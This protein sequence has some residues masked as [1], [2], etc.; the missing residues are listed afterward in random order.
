MQKKSSL[1]YISLFSSAG[2]GC[3][4][5]K[6]AQFSCLAT[7]E[8]LQKRIKFQKFNA[9]CESEDGY[10]SDDISKQETKN[11][12]IEI[13][14]KGLKKL[15]QST[16]DVLI[17]T[18]P[19]Q[20]M[21][22]A[23]HKKGDELPRNSLVIDSISLIK[24]L[25]PKIFVFE[26]V[27]S[28]LKTSCLDVDGKNK[29]IGDAIH[30]NLYDQYKYEFRKINFCEYGSNSSRTRCLVIGVR[31][32]CVNISPSNLF[33]SKV[34]P[35]K[36]REV[37][38]NLPTLN[39]GEIDEND[40][41]H[42]FRTY[43]KEM[44]EWI[45]TIRE[46]QSAF[47]NTEPHKRPHAIKDGKLLEHKR[48]NGDKYRRQILDKV[49]PCVHTRNDIL[50]SQNTVHPTEDRVF[51]IRELMRMMTIP[52]S[53][54]FSELSFKTL[55]NLSL[56]EKNKFL[57]NEELNIRHCIG[58]AVPTNIFF[59]I[60]E[61]IK[62]QFNNITETPRLKFAHFQTKYKVND[63]AQLAKFI[64][65]HGLGD[66][67]ISDFQSFSELL[68][69]SKEEHAAYYTNPDLVEEIVEN[70]PA[71]NE[72]RSIRILEPSVGSGAFITEIIKKYRDKNIT[73]DV[74]DI[75]EDA[76]TVLKSLINELHLKKT[77]KINYLIGD[78]LLHKFKK[79]YD[80]VIGNPPFLKINK[81]HTNHDFYKANARNSKSSNLFV[82]F[83]E[84]AIDISDYVCLIIPKSITGSPEFNETRKELASMNFYQIHDF[85]EHG[86]KGVLI[87]TVALGFYT[88]K[89]NTNNQVKILSR[90]TNSQFIQKQSY[91]MSSEFP[92][93]LLYR[94]KFFDEISKTLK[95]DSFEVF[96]DRQITSKILEKN[97]PYRVL[98][99]ANIGDCEVIDTD[100]DFYVSSLKGLAVAK[101]LNGSNL[102]L[103]PN[104]SYLPRACIKPK[105]T[106][107]DGSSAILIRKD[108][109]K[110]SLKQLKFFA[111]DDFRKFYRNCRNYSS[112]SMNIDS[113]YVFYFG[114]KDG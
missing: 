77:V 95:F 39:W 69:T 4:G 8:L 93:W 106:L 67:T 53:F 97:G 114:L 86:F 14:L 78:F 105:G 102:V 56:E 84:R 72:K 75:N 27:P 81:N 96:R 49:A 63:Q 111:S 9:I 64:A 70:L 15:S 100:K 101:Y 28:F 47:D 91:I 26:N 35:P 88:D 90:I 18:P 25:T 68:N 7:V 112:R 48:G 10:I 107:V 98:K 32:D 29:T 89:R 99:S 108:S 37:L 62:N 58:E 6:Q 57:K 45:G 52:A 87:E 79:K 23:N 17:A 61:N 66:Y 103:V 85:G 13:T 46:G 51:S 71:F 33:P 83:L 16:L 1:S 21:S 65:K 113:N 12:I 22:V 76:I 41:F 109:K 34:E 50:A 3:F 24:K 44:R 82:Y 74:L 36:L 20:G 80:L 38:A 30:D 40:I 11:Q 60:A 54:K 59:K 110:T 43:K 73:I 19:C 5:F 92:T 31:R 55:N 2:I 94:N 42:S 104:L